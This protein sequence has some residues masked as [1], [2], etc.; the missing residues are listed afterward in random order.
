[1]H[2]VTSLLL[3]ALICV[4]LCHALIYTDTWAAHIEGGEEIART[5]AEKHG[6]VFL[7]KVRICHNS[8]E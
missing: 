7:G 2:S 4:Q 3:G 5:L 6:F 1:M 8:G